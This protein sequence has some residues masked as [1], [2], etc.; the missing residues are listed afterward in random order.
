MSIFGLQTNELHFV[1][2]DDATGPDGFQEV[3]GRC[4]YGKNK[5]HMVKLIANELRGLDESGD[6]AN[7]TKPQV[8][9]KNPKKWIGTCPGDSQ[10]V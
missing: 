7:M 5:E 10:L 4:R 6:V 9:H 8:P 1:H 2:A 3:L